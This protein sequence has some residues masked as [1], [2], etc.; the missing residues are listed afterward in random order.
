MNSQKTYSKAVYFDGFYV[1][2][3]I[4]ILIINLIYHAKQQNKRHKGG[5]RIEL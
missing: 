1:I 5:L 2:I 3:K 4:N